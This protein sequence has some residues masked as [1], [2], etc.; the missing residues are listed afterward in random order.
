RKRRRHAVG[1]VS[2][3]GTDPAA[4]SAMDGETPRRAPT[5]RDPG[6]PHARSAALP[7]A[8]DPG[9]NRA[10]RRI[11]GRSAVSRRPA[12]ALPSLLQH[13]GRDDPANRAPTLAVTPTKADEPVRPATRGAKKRQAK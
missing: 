12:G 3:P 2:T 6:S 9:R 4:R 8:G 7:P 1:R 11:A 10:A 5:G 13:G